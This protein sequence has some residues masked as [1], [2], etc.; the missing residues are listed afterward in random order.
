MPAKI[1]S[2]YGHDGMTRLDNVCPGTALTHGAPGVIIRLS[3]VCRSPVK[4][5]LGL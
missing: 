3:S 4:T 5:A 2:H 1:K